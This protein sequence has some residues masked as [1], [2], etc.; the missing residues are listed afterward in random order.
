MDEKPGLGCVQSS[1]Q[2]PAVGEAGSQLGDGS[3]A[4][5]MALRCLVVPDT[6]KT[7]QCLMVGAL[8]GEASHQ[9]RN[10]FTILH[11]SEN[12]HRPKTQENTQAGIN[13][14]F[15]QK[16]QK[17]PEAEPREPILSHKL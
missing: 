4:V 17:D 3:Q 16:P 15:L 12:A 5:S 6:N 8:G 14:N 10:L 9:E 1:G 7:R 2:R 13:S 11:K